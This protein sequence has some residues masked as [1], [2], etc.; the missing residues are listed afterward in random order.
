MAPEQAGGP[1]TR[2]GPAADVYALGAILYELL[3]G[4][5]PFKGATAL[6]TVVQVLHEEPVRPGRLRPGLPRD[7]E[8]ICLK[9]L[10]KDP[11]KRYAGAAELA[12]DLQRFRQ[13]KPI[14]ARPVGLAERA[15][16]WAR[17]RPV[18]ALLLAALS[19]SVVL[20]FGGVTWQWQ[21]AARARDVALAEQRAKEDQRQRAERAR[22]VAVAE[23]KKARAALYYS[24]IAQSRLQWQVNDIAGAER[25]LTKCLPQPRQE[26]R[27]GWEWYYLRGLFHTELFTLSHRRGGAGGAVAFRPDGRRVASV[28]G[29]P[30]GGARPG[31]VRVWDAAG[32]KLVHLLPAPGTA[33]RLVF[34][35]DGRRL[36]LATTDGAVLVWDAAT[37]KEIL[38]R[39][40]HGDSVA[41]LAYSPD[42][43]FLASASWDRTVKLW[44]AATG[45][46][47][48]VLRGHNGPVH[49]VA[50]HPAGET[51]ASAGW[52]G[53]VKVW[54]ARTG[55]PCKNLA[56]HKS[57]V[58]GVA[59]S[60][61]GALL[62]SAGSNGNLKIWDVGAGRVVQS[63]TGH[64]GAVLGIAFSPDGRYLAYGGGDATV[65][66]WDIESG[67]DRV[68]FRGHRA[69]VEGLQF[70]PDGQRL[71]STSPAQGAVKIWD[72]TRHPERGTFAR[73]RGRLA[74]V[75]PVRDL[76]RNPSAATP[77]QTGPDVEGLAF[78]AGGRQLVSITV[79][80]KLQT[81]DVATGLLQD[82]RQLPISEELVSP[83][84]LAAFSPKGDHVAG[85]SREDSR[86]VRVWGVSTGAEVACLRGHTLPVFCVRFSADGR[87]LAT[88]ACDTRGAGRPHEIKVWDVAG[89]KERA[90]LAGRGQVYNLG[91][92]PDGRWLALGG[93]NGAVSVVDWAGSRKVVRAPGHKGPVAGLAFSRDGRLLATAGVEDLTV[94]V[95]NLDRLDRDR[96]ETLEAAH[97]LTAPGFLCDLAFSPD[98]RRL[99]GI[100]RDLVTL[101]EVET[102]HEVLTLRGAPQRHW[103]PAFNPRV[104]F[105]PDGKRLLGTNWD[106]SISLWEAEVEVDDGAVARR[107]TARRRGADARAVFWHLQEAEE[108]LD[109][110]NRPAA[111]FHFQRLGRAALPAPLQAR[112]ERLAAQLK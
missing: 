43:R 93:E 110:N 99:A 35:P 88:C 82:Q 105:S 63:L 25:S 1:A 64:A 57:A 18:S 84:V 69:A 71:A 26:D 98:G 2:V 51:L 89:G 7:L 44:D 73:T 78:R 81:W 12:D 32:G 96:P 41:G 65:R 56:G 87:L 104:T 108:C 103:D 100:S 77:A 94:K 62:A 24:R 61:D 91:F 48:H 3:T 28:V 17:R 22:A 16:K 55:K 13:G 85:R 14:L 34:R 42:G 38:R 21:E 15:W 19:L 20:G 10:Q 90:A 46:V 106:E 27:R 86:L 8:T 53:Q 67:V 39:S 50:F 52:D 111:R 29:G 11:G 9:C 80:G 101:W 74:K 23:R 76:I 59:F 5:P 79:G 75:V 6:D 45:R 40:H 102:E 37:G 31:E 95:W 4:R 112:K 68:V 33:H 70:S 49:G 30:G 107:Q 109:H 92:S 72:L 58:Y 36:A 47:I 83:A 54:D 60:P 66:V 97:S